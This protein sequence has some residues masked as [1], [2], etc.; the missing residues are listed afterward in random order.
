MISDWA[1]FLFI[2]LSRRCSG[3]R[4]GLEILRVVNIAEAKEWKECPGRVKKGEGD[5]E[6]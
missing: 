4:S 5:G 1:L 2:I 3:G 6:S